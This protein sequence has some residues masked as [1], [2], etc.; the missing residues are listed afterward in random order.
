LLVAF[1]CSAVSIIV[2]IFNI[3]SVYLGWISSWEIIQAFDWILSVVGIGF[4]IAAGILLLVSRV[5]GQ[6][7]N[8]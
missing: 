1:L 3:C 7:K 5:N 8:V 6:Q 4:S 2:G